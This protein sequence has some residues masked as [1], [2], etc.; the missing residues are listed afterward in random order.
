MSTIYPRI[1]PAS[2][3][4]HFVR[5]RGLERA[6]EVLIGGPPN[7]ADHK[8]PRPFPSIR[9]GRRENPSLKVKSS[10]GA[11][12]TLALRLKPSPAPLNRPGR[13]PYM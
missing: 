9:R 12:G 4:T 13:R 2:T 11:E 7:R 8:R 3:N 5:R 1:D 10:P 6:S